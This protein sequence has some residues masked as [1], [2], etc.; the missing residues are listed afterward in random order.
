M[1]QRGC[2]VHGRRRED[3]AAR[4][5]RAPQSCI[6]APPRKLRRGIVWS[7][8]SLCTSTPPSSTITERRRRRS[9]SGSCATPAASSGIHGATP[10]FNPARPVLR[11][12]LAGRAAPLACRSWAVYAGRRPRRPSQAAEARCVMAVWADTSLR[13]NPDFAETAAAV[14]K[15]RGCG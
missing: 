11:R 12:R 2:F 1:T 10:A 9:T 14:F 7:D 13:L 3:Q 15:A 8:A 5:V 4:A 6:R